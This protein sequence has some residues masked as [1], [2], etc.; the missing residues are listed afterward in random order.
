MPHACEILLVTDLLIILEMRLDDH[1]DHC[2]HVN[3]GLHMYLLCYD[4]GDVND[5]HNIHSL[6]LGYDPKQD[7]DYDEYSCHDYHD[8]PQDYAK[9]ED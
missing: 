9:N 2:D 4:S 3:Y 6:H 8:L 5:D 1:D 7:E